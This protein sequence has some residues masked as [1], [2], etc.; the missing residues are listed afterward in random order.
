MTSGTA[1]DRVGILIPTY[2][3]AT[4][5][6]KALQSATA[7]TW[8]DLEIIV[9]DNGS[10]DGTAGMMAA[11]EDPRVRY[12]VNEEN[13]GLIGS[14]NR[15]MRLFSEAVCWATILPDDDLLD[16]HFVEGM[17]A[18]V[19][20]SEPRAIICG[21]AVLIDEEGAIIR[22]TLPPPHSETSFEYLLN[23]VNMKRETFLTGVFF[24]REAFSAIGGYPAFTTGMGTDDAFIFALAGR[25]RLLYSRDA[26]AYVR[27]HGD[28]E[29]QQS[30]GGVRHIQALQDFRAYVRHL[31]LAT[32]QEEGGRR[33][34]L[35]A[36]LDR[37]LGRQASGLWVRNVKLLFKARPGDLRERLDELLGVVAGKDDVAF[38]RRVR[39]SAWITRKTGRCPEAFL[40]YRAPWE[41]FRR[42]SGER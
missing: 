29:S 13:L 5:L 17:L 33:A 34:E 23:R 14:L 28:A 4:Y 22:E 2:N 24:S 20:A 21:K 15:G 37:Y 12:L 25:D 36:A 27:I 41:M 7:Q 40:W 9:I 38:S 32:P 26:M 6:Q 1:S 16:E 11:I 42:V 10:S 35:E 18:L 3:R 19:R 31:L 30:I 39:I 8:R